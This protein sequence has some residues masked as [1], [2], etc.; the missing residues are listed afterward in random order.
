MF[1]R[2][3]SKEDFVRLLFIISVTALTLLVPA[4]ARADEGFFD[5]KGVKIRYITEGKGEPVVLLHALGASAEMWSQTEPKKVNV[6]AALAKEYR[7]IA[8]DCRGHGKSDKPHD[9][10]K[11]G[12][13]MTED[14]VRLLDHLK[15]KKTHVIGYS[16]GAGI[17]GDLLVRH[18]DRV[19]SVTLGAGGPLFE[20]SRKA[21][22]ETGFK[23]IMESW[24]AQLERGESKDPIH[25]GKD[26]KALAAVIRS[27]I[28]IK[29]TT[30]EQLKANKRPAFVVY[31][32]ID[33]GIEA[34]IKQYQELAKLLGADAKVIEGGLHMGTDSSPEFLEAVQGFLKKHKE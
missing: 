9:V 31:G 20:P 7:V 1:D 18:P 27:M 25:K 4:L 16:M 28:K 23:E 33:M 11:Y 5:A 21:K 22:A 12:T 24:A 13:E 6:F 8:M 34:L 3:L 32:S 10:E 2:F 26:Q 29:P 15:I 14:V 17:A 30:E 19:L